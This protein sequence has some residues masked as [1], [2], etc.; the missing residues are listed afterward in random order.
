MDKQKSRTSVLPS[1]QYCSKTTSLKSTAPQEVLLG[2]LRPHVHWKPGSN[3]IPCHCSSGHL[4]SCPVLTPIYKLEK[5]GKPGHS[6]APS[7]FSLKDLASLGHLF[8]VYE[9]GGPGLF[10]CGSVKLALH[11]PIFAFYSGKHTK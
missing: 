4:H 7:I 6:L 2:R 11:K 1:L 8:P 3:Y 9:K 5:M 10:V